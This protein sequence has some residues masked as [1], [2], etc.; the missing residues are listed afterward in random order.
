MIKELEKLRQKLKSKE[1]ENERSG[2][3]H[4][5][6]SEIDFAAARAYRTAADEL[7]DIIAA[8]KKKVADQNE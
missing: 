6:Q 7:S 1:F 5:R 8:E 3:Q 4:V 2:L